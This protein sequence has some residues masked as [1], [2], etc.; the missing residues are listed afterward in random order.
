MLET[1]AQMICTVAITMQ[2]RLPIPVSSKR[3]TRLNPETSPK[4][5]SETVFRLDGLYNFAVPEKTASR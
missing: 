3:Y 1:E 2:R 5:N 4:T